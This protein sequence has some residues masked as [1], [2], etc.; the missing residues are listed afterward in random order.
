MFWGWAGQ[1]FFFWTQR[2]VES[3][4][5]SSLLGLKIIVLSLIYV[6]FMQRQILPLQWVAVFMCAVSAMGMNFTGGRISPKGAFLLFC[7]LLSYSLSDIFSLELLLKVESNSIILKSLAGMALSY[8]C[9]GLA[10]TFLLFRTG[11]RMVWLRDAAPYGICWF[12]AMITL[13][14]CFGTTG[15]IFGNIVQATRGIISV[16]LG[17]LL[18]KLG[19]HYLEP[20]VSGKVWLRRF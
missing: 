2:E 8:I 16:L 12:L 4:R 20:A 13:F 6:F 18:L 19:F 1:F 5:L 3:S 11:F 17:A 9:Y 10:G 14:V 15:V 7:T